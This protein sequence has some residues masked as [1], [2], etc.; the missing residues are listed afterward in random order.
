MTRS[1]E[2][3]NWESA[4]RTN[5]SENK[6]SGNNEKVVSNPGLPQRS[7]F[8]P[9][10]KTTFTFLVKLQEANPYL[11][12]MNTLKLALGPNYS[13]TMLLSEL[14]THALDSVFR[15]TARIVEGKKYCVMQIATRQLFLPALLALYISRQ[16]VSRARNSEARRWWASVDV[17]P[18]LHVR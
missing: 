14:I 16:F 18:N 4:E 15:V 1:I 6:K 8:W 11:T 9:S 7:A 12:G 3:K 17:Y 2:I 5:T 13:H 10:S